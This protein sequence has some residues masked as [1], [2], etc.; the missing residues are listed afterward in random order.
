MYRIMPVLRFGGIH[1]NHTSDP[2]PSGLSKTAKCLRLCWPAAGGG[3]SFALQERTP[4][5]SAAS[6]R[7]K[8]MCCP[9]LAERRCISG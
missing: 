2:E 5:I 3:A 8:L 4:G 1:K 9:V 6:L 7:T